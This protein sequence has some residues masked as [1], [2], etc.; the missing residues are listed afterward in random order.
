MKIKHKAPHLEKLKHLDVADRKA[1]KSYNNTRKRKV[2][3]LKKR[4]ILKKFI[5]EHSD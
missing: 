3:A 5:L 1:V 2:R 4:N